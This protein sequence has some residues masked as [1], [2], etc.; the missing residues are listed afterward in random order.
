MS[1]P[2]K[3]L[4]DGSFIKMAE[5]VQRNLV[6]QEPEH[7]SESHTVAYAMLPAVI[8]LNNL[9]DVLF[10]PDIEWLICSR[11]GPS[12]KRWEIP[13][14]KYRFFTPGRGHVPALGV[15]V[16]FDVP[17][18]FVSSSCSALKIWAVSGAR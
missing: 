8:D 10:A 11:S 2:L 17:F 7:Q 12:L 14:Y 3:I 15:F 18:P 16:F 6:P 5:P 4:F 9:L 1:Q 13:P